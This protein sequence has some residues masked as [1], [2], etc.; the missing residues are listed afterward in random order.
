MEVK[1][2][3]IIKDLQELGIKSNEP[4]KEKPVAHFR[5]G[6][7]QTA[8]WKN[9]SEEGKEYATITLQRSYKD[10]HGEWKNTN[11]LRKSDLLTASYLLT[12]TFSAL[13]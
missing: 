8:V 6:N 1:I 5:A 12:K 4:T 3:P 11:V 13:E 7:L 9:N 2:M 10:K